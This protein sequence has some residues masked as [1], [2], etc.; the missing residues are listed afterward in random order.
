MTVIRPNSISGVTSI[1]AQANEINVFKHDGVLAGLQLNGVNH[2]T[3]SGV[4][5]FHTLN[6]L[7]NVSVGGTLT[8]Q[9]V[10]NIDSVGLITARSGIDCN[11]TLEVSSTSNFDGAVQIADTILHLGDTNTKIRFPAA[12]TIT[13]ET[14]GT[15]RLRITSGGKIGIN[16]A[17][18]TFAA[19]GGVHLKGSGT[20]FT[21]YRVTASSNTGVDFSQASDGKGYVYNRDNADLIVGTNNTE[22][23]RIRSDGKVVIGTNY[24]GGT[25][26]VTGN[27]ITDDGT[28]GRITIQADGTSTNQI[29]STTTG[30]ASYC[31]MKYQAA[32]HIFL[33]G[34]TERFRLKNDGNMLVGGHTSALSTYNSSQPRLSVYKSSG[35]GGYLELGGNIP[36]NGHSSGTI[37]FINNDNSDA[38]NNNANGKI[39]AMQRVE[40][41]TSDT[42]AGDD[43][44]GDLTFNIKP[45]SGSLTERLRIKADGSTFLQTSNVN[46]NRGTSGAGYPLTVRGPADG[47]TIRIERANSYQ[48]HI[49]QDSNSNLYFKAN[50]TKEVVFPTGGGIAFNGETS[51]S[52][53]LNDYEYGNWNA[54][55][56]WNGGNTTGSYA[57]TTA[58]TGTYVKVGHVVHGWITVYPNSYNSGSDCVIIG[59]TL[60][61]SPN[62]QGAVAFAPYSGQGNYGGWLSVSTYPRTYA[63]IDT[64]NN[65]IQLLVTGNGQGAGFWGHKSGTVAANAQVTVTYYD[66]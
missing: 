31:N 42:N 30:F 59:I 2:H 25:L 29:L 26:S 10:T 20:D 13:A 38:T 8:Y 49:G 56:Q 61:T 62:Q 52:N 18:P 32:D 54:T 63:S 7:G 14:G 23:L 9:D 53:S 34:G 24:T 55:V 46:I 60:P 21:S 66:T 58:V 3:S 16:N 17:S 41:S 51:A 47:D 4:S 22:R 33:Y 35:S 43:M 15:E 65:R 5:T 1:T 11:G 19:G 50:A 12:D 39:L 57:H 36:H 6:V 45:E 27:L 64:G 48:W 44:G 28:N 37:L 40:N